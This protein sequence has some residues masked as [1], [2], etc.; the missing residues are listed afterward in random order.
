MPEYAELHSTSHAVNEASYGHT[1]VRCEV[2]LDWSL[3]SSLEAAVDP[4]ATC[5]PLPTDAQLEAAG[6]SHAGAYMG[7]LPQVR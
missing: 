2:N 3:P 6:V 5:V 7:S 4:L 1:F